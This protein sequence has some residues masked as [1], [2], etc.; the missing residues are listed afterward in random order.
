MAKHFYHIPLQN[1]LTKT[2]KSDLSALIRE[3]KRLEYHKTLG[4]SHYTLQIEAFMHFFKI[5]RDLDYALKTLAYFHSSP[6]MT[7]MHRTLNLSQFGLEPDMPQTKA[8][9]YALCHLYGASDPEGFE[10]FIQKS[11]LHYHTAFQPESDIRI[12]HQEIC[13]ALAQTR[14]I[15]I[16]ESF[17]EEGSEAYFKIRLDG[18]LTID[19]RGKRIKTLRKKA[20]RKLFYRLIDGEERMQNW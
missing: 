16:K 3:P 12:D 17:G 4:K 8:L 7:R 20:Y 11:L 9:F 15:T 2:C 5:D 10:L 19:E 6:F 13:R 18:T 1:T 14:K